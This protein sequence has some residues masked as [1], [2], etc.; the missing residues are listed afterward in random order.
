MDCLAKNVTIA[1]LSMQI[2]CFPT[3]PDTVSQPLKAY[4]IGSD[5]DFLTPI[6]T[7]ISCAGMYENDLPVPNEIHSSERLSWWKKPT[8][9]TTTSVT[10]VLLMAFLCPVIQACISFFMTT[11]K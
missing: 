8:A 5:H 7:A 10:T 3:N 4:K 9:K 2:I 6:E 11:R 1:M